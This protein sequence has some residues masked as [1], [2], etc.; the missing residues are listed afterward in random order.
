MDN[1]ELGRETLKFLYQNFK[2]YFDDGKIVIAGSFYYKKL[3]CET[4]TS[5][6]DVDLSIDKDLDNVYHDV[7]NHI[8][9][10]YKLDHIDRREGTGQIGSFTVKGYL[11]VDLFRDDFS[12]LL[13]PKEIIPGVISFGLS[14]KVMFNIYKKL[15][16]RSRK[17]IQKYKEIKEFFK[18]RLENGSKIS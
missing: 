8:E 3:G 13:P 4:G 5:Y 16:E 15:E 7:L 11:G 1:F 6:K 14:D 9:Q 17:D 18:N 2:N 10:N 12:D